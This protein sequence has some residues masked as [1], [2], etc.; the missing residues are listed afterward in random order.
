MP[1]PDSII[2]KTLT[3]VTVTGR[4]IGPQAFRDQTNLT[5]VDCD[6]LQIVDEASFLDCTG[7][8]TGSLSFSS[9]KY[10]GS[11]AFAGCTGLSGALNLTSAVYIGGNAFNRCTN[12]TEIKLGEDMCVLY[13]TTAI[14]SS[15][16]AIKVPS[17][18]VEMY[19]TYPEWSDLASKIVSA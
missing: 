15:V 11:S 16:T 7:I 19:K 17:D 8:T 14:P 4:Y 3:S 13:S 5:R 1:I 12:L 18:R 9:L 2:N 6:D 10:I